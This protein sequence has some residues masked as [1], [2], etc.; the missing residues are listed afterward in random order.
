MHVIA[1]K[2]TAFL[3]ALKPE[4]KVY[5]QQVVKN[6]QAMVK[7]LQ[8]RGYRIISGRTESHVFLVDLRPKGLTGKRAD[9]LLGQAHITV[10]KNSI[11]NDPESPF[12]TS[13]IRLGT[14]AITTR[15]FTENEA[16]Q[17]A[18]FIADVLDHPDEENVIQDVKVKVNELTSNFPVYEK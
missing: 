10:N 9:Q 17:V 12:V 15:G 6:A 7:T 11:P 3:E 18:N 1:A 16:N 5:Q 4:F 8:E 14:P 13:G 2:A